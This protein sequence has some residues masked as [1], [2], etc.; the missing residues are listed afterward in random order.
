MEYRKIIRLKDGRECCIRNGTR[1]DGKAALENFILTHEET[2]FLLTYPEEITFTPEAEGNFLQKKAE[3]PGE[4]ELL[5]EM[6][7][8]IIGLAGISAIGTALKVR[9][10]AQFGIS[11][12][13]EFWG[14][15]AGRALTEACT[16][17]AKRAG[18]RQLELEVS[19]DNE[20]ALALYRK[21]G[22][23]EYG[24]NPCGFRNKSGEYQELVL[25]R[26]DLQ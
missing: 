17:C 21:E 25:M 7:G 20:A 11:I 8:E 22:F 12:I 13:K 19:A 1:E 15:G 9:H 6:D 14:L 24:R 3:N 10:R 26:L 16:E 5:A 2:D 4:A 23:A 18:Y